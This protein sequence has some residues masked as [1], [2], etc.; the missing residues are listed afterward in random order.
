MRAA[1]R[2]EQQGARSKATPVR[3]PTTAVDLVLASVG[4][5]L[6]LLESSSTYTAARCRS[7]SSLIYM[8]L[9]V[10]VIDPVVPPT[11]PRAPRSIQRRTSARARTSTES[12]L[13][14]FDSIAVL[15]I[16]PAVTLLYLL[17]WHVLVD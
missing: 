8:Y 2:R 15:T 4:T 3:V 13:N 1:R 5:A 6:V 9:H 14:A 17:V 11:A 16:P 12:A 7:T 10:L